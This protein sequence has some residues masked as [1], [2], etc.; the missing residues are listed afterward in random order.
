MIYK[1]HLL[2][3]RGHGANPIREV[4]VN[5]PVNDVEGLLEQIFYNGQNYVQLRDKC[6]SVSVGDVI[7]LKEDDYHLVMPVGFLKITPEA[8][9][10]WQQNSHSLIMDEEQF[11]QEIAQAQS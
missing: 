2:A 6:F 8:F 5:N 9:G 7:E 10:V 3:F 1:V 4:E 11:N